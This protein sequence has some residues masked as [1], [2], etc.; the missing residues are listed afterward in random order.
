MAANDGVLPKGIS[1]IIEA[2]LEA[3]LLKGVSAAIEAALDAAKTP[4]R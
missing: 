1:A 4:C 3:T 2:A